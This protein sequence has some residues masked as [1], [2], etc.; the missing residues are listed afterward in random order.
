VITVDFRLG[1]GA[2][3]QRSA[4]SVGSAFSTGHRRTGSLTFPWDEVRAHGG[5][6]SAEGH[7]P[8]PVLGLYVGTLRYAI[9]IDDTIRQLASDLFCAT[10]KY[11]TLTAQL[12]RAIHIPREFL[13]D[14]CLAAL[15]R[16]HEAKHA[17]A[18]AIPLDRSRS[19]LLSAIREAVRASTAAASGSRPDAL[20]RLTTGIQTAVNR[21]FDDMATERRRLDAAVDSPAELERLKTGCKGRASQ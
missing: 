17:D 20:A 1:A 15:A 2:A 12:D 9:E 18:D 6:A 21:V 16:D 11:V 13:G 10:P 3:L 19:S 7:H 5:G 4:A 14:P 8:G